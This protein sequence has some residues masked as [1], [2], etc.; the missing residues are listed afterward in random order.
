MADEHN[1]IIAKMSSTDR[2]TTPPCRGWA[3]RS[4]WALAR[5]VHRA[6]SAHGAAHPC[7]AGQPGPVRRARNGP[8]RAPAN[9]RRAGPTDHTNEFSR[10]ESTQV[11]ATVA[12]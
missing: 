11:L 10:R 2:T 8:T 7:W 6:N 1:M 4:G 9:V 12:A 3:P 5:G